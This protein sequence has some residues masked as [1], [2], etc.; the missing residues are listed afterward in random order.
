MFTTDAGGHCRLYIVDFEHA[1]FLPISFLSYV[2]FDPVPRW[3]LSDALVERIG[4]TLPR[5]NLE[6]MTKIGYTFQ[7]FTFTIGLT[8][9][10]LQSGVYNA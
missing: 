2:V 4:N 3:S 1:S 10:Q 9:S 8:E 5:G 7:V 6:V